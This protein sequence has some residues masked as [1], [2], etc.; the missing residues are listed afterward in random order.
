MTALHHSSLLLRTLRPAGLLMLLLLASL[1]CFPAIADDSDDDDTV[2][3]RQDNPGKGKVLRLAT[4]GY[5][6]PYLLNVLVDEEQVFSKTIG[7]DVWEDL[8]I[9]LAKAAQTQ[10]AVVLELVVPE[11]QRW[12][13]G[14]WFDYIDFFEN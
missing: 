10:A 9:P 2:E 11:D 13:E 6:F 4:Q 5:N 1:A 7:K 12:H 3:E 8:Q 14:A